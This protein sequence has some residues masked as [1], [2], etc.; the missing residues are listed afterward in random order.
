[1]QALNKSVQDLSTDV[2]A[3]REK[4]IGQEKDVQAMRSGLAVLDQRLEGLSKY[5][6]DSFEAQKRLTHDRLEKATVD[7]LTAID[8]V[9]A[10]HAKQPKRK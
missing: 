1:M 5:W 10:F 8:A 3:L 4:D 9:S 6:R 7:L 2:R